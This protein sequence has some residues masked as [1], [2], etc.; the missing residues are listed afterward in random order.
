V[1]APIPEQLVSPA[2]GALVELFEIDLTPIDPSAP[3]IF[4][5]PEAGTAYNVETANTVATALNGAG[6]VDL[7]PGENSQFTVGAEI[8]FPLVSG[9]DHVATVTN[10]TTGV[11]LFFTPNILADC[12]SGSTVTQNGGA[13]PVARGGQTYIPFPISAEGY[14]RGGTGA[15][16]EPTLAVANV[17]QTLGPWVEG[18]QDLLGAEVTRVVVLFDWLDGEPDAD[19]AAAISTDR[20]VVAQKSAQD[21]NHVAFKLRSPLDVRRTVPF[22]KALPRCSHTYRRWVLGA[23]VQGS[24]PYTGAATF[25]YYDAP[26]AQNADDVCHRK[27]SSCVAR[28]G[29]VPLPFLGFP[30]LK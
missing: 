11:S 24:C 21:K 15:L 4:V 26:V 19:P 7:S 8:S 22:R 14:E 17:E 23:F 12:V 29:D 18:A 13:L 16:P 6:N 10:T 5:T 28:F 20:Y 9:A 25:D 3:R 1:S 2:P 30:G 27:L